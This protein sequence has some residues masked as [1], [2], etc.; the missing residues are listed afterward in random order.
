MAIFIF[1]SVFVCTRCT[2]RTL[3]RIKQFCCIT[4]FYFGKGLFYK[5]THALAAL[6]KQ[7]CCLRVVYGRKFYYQLRIRHLN[8][9]LKF[10]TFRIESNQSQTCQFP[11]RSR[12]EV[13]VSNFF[14]RALSAS[15]NIIGCLQTNFAIFCF[16]LAS[17]LVSFL[18]T[19]P[20]GVAT[21]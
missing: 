16:Q 6:L 3:I 5:Q 21:L 14:E 11:E 8:V 12:P 7:K 17:R 15:F 10:S 1:R 19:G 13:T 2:E 4:E 18:P 20:V 9:L